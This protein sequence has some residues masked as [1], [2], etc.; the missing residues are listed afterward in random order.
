VRSFE[1][2]GGRTLTTD[3]ERVAEGDTPATPE[4]LPG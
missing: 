3:V 1:A 2:M 4:G